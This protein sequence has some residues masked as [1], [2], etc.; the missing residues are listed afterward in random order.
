MI[1][2]AH[3]KFGSCFIL[4]VLFLPFFFAFGSSNS[5]DENQYD[6]LRNKSLPSQTLISLAELCEES[7]EK[8]STETLHDIPFIQFIYSLSSRH[9]LVSCVAFSKNSHPSFANT[10]NIPLYLAKQVFL[11]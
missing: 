10:T 1:K 2:K 3:I 4:L 6:T 5:S 9:H 8:N 7:E 11:I